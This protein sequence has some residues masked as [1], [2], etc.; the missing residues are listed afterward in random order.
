MK[1]YIDNYSI[2]NLQKKIKGLNKYL[3]N[4]TNVIEV[5]SDEGIFVIDQQNI[6]KIDYLDKPI[7]KGKYINENDILFDMLIDTT[8]TT[9]TIVN[10]LPPDNVI[11]KTETHEYQ[12]NTSSKTKLVI[13]SSLNKGVNE[14]KPHDFY[15]D[16]SNDIDINSPIFKED[17]N[18]F[19]FH[20]N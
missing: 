10:Q 8:E 20:L 7:K 16:V 1:I 14:Y 4:K 15:F 13:N 9:R 5:Y 19:L 3:T 2:K 6:Y 18:V 11:I 12:I 17:I